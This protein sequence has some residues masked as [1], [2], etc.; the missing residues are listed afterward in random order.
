MRWQRSGS[1]KSPH[2]HLFTL[3]G[4]SP[5]TQARNV[6]LQ[7]VEGGE[8]KWQASTL[9]VMN[10]GPDKMVH[11]W[12]FDIPKPHPRNKISGWVWG[13]DWELLCVCRILHTRDGINSFLQQYNIASAFFSTTVGDVCVIQKIRS[14]SVRHKRTTAL[15]IFNPIARVNI[16][17]VRFC[18]TQ[19]C[20]NF[21]FLE[22]ATVSFFR[23]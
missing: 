12:T 1:L 6:N 4:R 5:R 15:W 3:T 7:V 13:F 22:V 9:P 23:S 17:N 18:K 8:E 21:T 11:P 16:S 10:L 20:W 19:E 2:S 14:I